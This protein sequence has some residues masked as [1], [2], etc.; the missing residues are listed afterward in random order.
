MPEPNGNGNG[1]LVKI[2]GVLCA[3]LV[4]AAGGLIQLYGDVRELKKSSGLE[5][6]VEVLEADS[7]TVMQRQAAGSK[8]VEQLN[9]DQADIK[10]LQ[11]DVKEL[12]N[13]RHR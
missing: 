7:K 2:V 1:L 3:G 11:A 5:K 6:R 12:K 4:G 9:R 10:E 13:T 8:Y